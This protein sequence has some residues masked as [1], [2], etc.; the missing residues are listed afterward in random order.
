MS[1]NPPHASRIIQK[2]RRLA[3]SLGI[4]GG[5]PVHHLVIATRL[6]VCSMYQHLPQRLILTLTCG[7]RSGR[8]CRKHLYRNI[9]AWNC[10]GKARQTGA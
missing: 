1:I 7:V 5:P 4:G 3:A 2:A 10:K 9:L 8:T 6:L